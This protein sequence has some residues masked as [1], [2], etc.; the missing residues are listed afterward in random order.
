MDRDTRARIAAWI[1]GAGLAGSTEPDLLRAFCAKLHAAGMPIAKANMLIDTLHPVYEGRVFLWRRDERDVDI[2]E[3]GRS[4]ES[5]E[6]AESWRTSPFNHLFESGEDALRRRLPP[7]GELEFPILEKLRGAGQTDYLAL[8]NRFAAEGIIGDM[9]CIYSSWTSDHADG[10]A[11]VHLEVL[12]ELVPSLALAM[13]CASLTRIAGTL[14]ETY[15]GQDAGARVLSGRIARGT[16]D[17]ISTVLWFSDL[18]G[19]THI[20]E[21]AAPEAI[22]PLLNDYAEAVIS[23]VHEAGG[24]VL[25]LIGDGTLAIFKGRDQAA[26]CHDALAAESL[27]RE[28]VA[29][30]NEERSARGV[31]VTEPYLGLHVGDVFY[32]NIGSRDRLD[33]TVVGP[34]VNEASRIAALCRSAERNVLVSSVFHAAAAGADRDRLVSVGRYALR[35]VSRPQELFTLESSDAEDTRSDAL[36]GVGRGG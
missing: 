11:D 25:K 26:A 16:A 31:P 8:I 21:T 35:G 22:I 1:T 14:V 30:L 27:M 9:D 32:G 28:R 5:D 15:L 24:N 4:D 20:T 7:D 19:F 3:Y 13:K 6:A 2:L 10:F 17:R 18:R 23:S 36:S 34:A 29:A 33:F 12:R